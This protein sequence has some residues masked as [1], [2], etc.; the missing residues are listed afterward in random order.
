[1]KKVDI[2]VEMRAY[3][4]RRF[5]QQGPAATYYGVT[6]SFISQIINGKCQPTSAML[7]DMGFKRKEYS[8]EYEAETRERRALKESK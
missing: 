3:V 7:S 1:M 2:A 8:P 6:P 5:K 4:A